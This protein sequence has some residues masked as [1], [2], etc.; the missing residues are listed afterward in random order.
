MDPSSGQMF[1]NMVS[2]TGG[3]LLVVLLLVF[4][5]PEIVWLAKILGMSGQFLGIQPNQE[6]LI[7]TVLRSETEKLTW[8][9]TS[10][11]LIFARTSFCRIFLGEFS[12][13]S[14]KINTVKRCCLWQFTKT[15]FTKYYRIAEQK[16]LKIFLI[17]NLMQN[18]HSQQTFE[19]PIKNGV[20]KMV[21]SNN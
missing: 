16:V 1:S 17:L 18:G 15:N 4:L 3:G 19:T 9:A 13:T 20:F 14:Q 11:K 7:W 8:A 2:V 10:T 6:Y 21:Y 5:V 12:L